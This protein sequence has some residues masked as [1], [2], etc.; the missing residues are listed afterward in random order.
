MDARYQ[1]LVEAI[2]AGDLK[3][4]RQ[5]ILEN[6]FILTDF[7]LLPP[8]E[9]LLCVAT[10]ADK[11]DINI[12]QELVRHRAE[13]AKELNGHGLRPPD[14]ASKNGNVE[15]VR[16]LVKNDAE[17][18]R[19]KG[20]DKRTALHHAAVH[21]RV[22]VIDVLVYVC[23]ESIKDVTAKGETALHLAVKSGQ[24]EAFRA[25]VDWLLRSGE[26]AIIN[27]G[28]CEENTV[29]HLAASTKQLEVIELLLEIRTTGVK[30]DVNA[31]NSRGLTAVNILNEIKK[32]TPADVEL[33]NDLKSASAVASKSPVESPL[34][35]EVQN[36]LLVVAVLF[37]TITFQGVINPPQY[38]FST[39]SSVGNS[40][41][42]TSGNTTTTP[43]TISGNT[44]NT[45][46]VNSPATVTTMITL[47][48]TVENHS[49]STL[50]LFFNTLVHTAAF[51]TIE[52][53]TR[54][55]V[56]RRELL[57][58]TCCVSVIYGFLVAKLAVKESV[59]SYLLY[60]AFFLPASQHE[61]VARVGI[62]SLEMAETT[63]CG[64]A[65]DAK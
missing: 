55:L 65:L 13:L 28:D 49:V 46:S 11:L 4:L 22:E 31:Q 19:L 48:G 59:P 3:V 16:E 37:V 34:G 29:L 41:T 40:S 10:C 32:P 24:F 57:V 52:L 5:L 56:F 53:V 12:V 15:I 38:I 43:N 21:G 44:I 18:C 64:A 39:D 63:P 42:S 6:P 62:Q 27:Q 23:S 50:F 9:P 36:L 1:A 47:I 14:I 17:M 35:T 26:E 60:I 20:K 25:L 51:T 30:V 45:N 8:Q 58:S 54:R 2:K 7:S 33:R 61:T